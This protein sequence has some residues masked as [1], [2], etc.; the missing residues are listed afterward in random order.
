[1]DR[2][3][4]FTLPRLFLLLAGLLLF[5]L[6]AF[7]GEH[8]T[9]EMP[10]CEKCFMMTLMC[11]TCG[12]Q[13]M[14]QECKDHMGTCTECP[15][16][17]PCEWAQEKIANGCEA[18]LANFATLIPCAT[19]VGGY[20]DCTL[21]S[22]MMMC[23]EHVAAMEGCADCASGTVCD[24]CKVARVECDACMAKMVCNKH[25]DQIRACE[26]CSTGGHCEHCFKDTLACMD[27]MALHMP[28][29]AME[30]MAGAAA[31]SE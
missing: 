21:C 27:C 29:E 16:G 18:C 8:G 30:A 28:P 9:E 12:P 3:I 15:A 20:M 31:D 17:T 7:A 4:H 11:E 22:A 19:C 14:C 5:S 2:Q 24:A 23:E 25:R 26:V 6:P 10:F 13:V 1:M